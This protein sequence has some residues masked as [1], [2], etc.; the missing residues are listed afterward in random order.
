M[1]LPLQKVPFIVDDG[2]NSQIFPLQSLEMIDSL[3][4][5]NCQYLLVDYGEG[6]Q[7]MTLL[8]MKLTPRDIL[9]FMELK[10]GRFQF[11]EN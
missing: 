6:P 1:G 3:S 10:D 5:R 11:N 9:G 8:Q 7:N 4:L 2:P